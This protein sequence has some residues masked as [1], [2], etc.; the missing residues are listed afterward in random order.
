M[1]SKL[2]DKKSFK[3]AARKVKYLMLEP[4]NYCNLDCEMPYMDKIFKK[5]MAK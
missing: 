5:E 2:I 1:K 4:T 3:A